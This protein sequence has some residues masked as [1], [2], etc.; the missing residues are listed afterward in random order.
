MRNVY[1]ICS[2]Y[3]ETMLATPLHSLAVAAE[4]GGQGGQLPPH[5]FNLLFLLRARVLNSVRMKS[6][7]NHGRPRPL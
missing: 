5:K 2:G 7:T 4:Q 1:R 6:I 3:A